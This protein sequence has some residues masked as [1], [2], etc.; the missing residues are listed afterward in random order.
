[1]VGDSW[2]QG[3]ESVQRGFLVRILGPSC[4]NRT[5]IGRLGELS[6]FWYLELYFAPELAAVAVELKL[7]LGRFLLVSHLLKN[8]PRQP[9]PFF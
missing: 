2:R 6:P 5:I 1:M 4:A 9:L 3:V 8:L 7:W